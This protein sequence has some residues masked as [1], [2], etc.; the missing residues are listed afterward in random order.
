M[1]SNYFIIVNPIA[2]RGSARQAVPRATQILKELGLSFDLAYTKW[3]WHAA[4]LARQGAASGYQ[5]VVSMGGDGTTNEVLNGLMQAKEAGEGGAILGVLCIGTGNDFAYGAGIPLDL[6][7][8]CKA[9]VRRRIRT[10]DVGHVVGLRYFCNGVGIGFD[11]VVNLQAARITHLR[12]FAVY[13]LAILRTILF[14]Y[15]AP[16]T[17]IEGDGWELEQ[18]MLMI[19]IMNGRRMGGGFLVTPESVPDDGLLDLCIGTRMNRLRMLSLVPRFMRGTQVG[20]P[21]ITMARSRWLR[22]TVKEGTQVVHSD[23]ETIS[24]DASSL[25]IKLIPEHLQVIY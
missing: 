2:G 6:E 19:S 18:P 9:L 23:G 14:Y 16:N 21:G 25:E 15:R 11:A 10:I 24:T 5:V 22:V 17:F 4:E 20:H 3:P 12:G 7:G 8:G 13:L 1:I